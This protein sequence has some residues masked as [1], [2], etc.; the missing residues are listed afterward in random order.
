MKT[1]A[2]KVMAFNKQLDFNIA[3]P[4][5]IRMMNPFKEN[6]ST[7]ETANAFYKKYYNDFN[8]RHIIFG[9]NPG[10][11]G[12]GVTG[13]PFTDSKRLNNVCGI[14]Y[15]GK[16]THEP[17]SVFV[18]DM[19]EAFGGAQSFY[20]RFYINSLCPL[21]FTSMND[22]GKEVNYN[23]YDNAD[24][25]A[26]MLEFII[27]NIQKQIALGVHTD[28]CYCFGTGKN[29]RKNSFILINIWMLLN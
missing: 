2:E 29:E 28:V 20:N 3:L 8:K 10:R 17:S 7:L 25:T 27:E 24:L 13:I 4:P 1:F 16:Q 26:T 23:Y 19:I 18:Y 11:F 14:A 9:I 21:G 12:G 6:K 15:T 22:E 5:G